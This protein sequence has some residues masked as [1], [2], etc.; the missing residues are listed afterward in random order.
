MG[1]ARAFDAEFAMIPALVGV[2]GPAR[3]GRTGWAFS[4]LAL[5][6]AGARARR[7]RPPFRPEQLDGL[8]G[9][10]IG[11]GANVDPARYEQQAAIEYVYDVERDEF[12]WQMLGAAMQRELPLL[13][14]CRGAQLLNVFAGGSLWQNLTQDIPGL[15]LRRHVLARK[16]VTIEPGTLLADVMRVHAVKVNS[17][18]RQGIRG[19]GRGLRIAAHDADGIVQAVEAEPNHHPFLLGVQWHPEYLLNHFPQ[20]RL[21]TRLIKAAKRL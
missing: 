16:D 4:W 20:R 7:L 12:E 14:I 13:G 15:Q 19:I 9:I 6:A 11:G 5:R 3:G 8:G 18:H 10:V 17:L 2:T 21:F 1:G